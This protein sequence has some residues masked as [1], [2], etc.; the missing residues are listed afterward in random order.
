[1]KS[2][3]IDHL[4]TM[5]CYTTRTA[6]DLTEEHDKELKASVWPPNSP[7]S[8]LTEHLWDVLDF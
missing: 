5:Q 3:N 6:Q 4:G 8:N 1:M 2:I 7:Y